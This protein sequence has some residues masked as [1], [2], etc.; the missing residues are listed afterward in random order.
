MREYLRLVLIHPDFDVAASMMT[1][2][3]LDDG[4]HCRAFTQINFAIEYL[5]NTKQDMVLFPVELVKSNNFT[6][7]KEILERKSHLL[8]AIIGHGGDQYSDFDTMRTGS[9]F[10]FLE[11]VEGLSSF[12]ETVKYQNASIN[13]PDIG[14]PH[15]A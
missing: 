2:L 4:F 15:N 8:V 13:E 9:N 6:L 5:E 7:L 10:T 11:S 3:R 1:R 12:L 14:I